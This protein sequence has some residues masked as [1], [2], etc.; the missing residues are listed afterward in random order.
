MR[1]LAIKFSFVILFS[2]I[3][4]DYA[5]CQKME[6]LSDLKITD[7]VY[8]I[9]D[10]EAEFPGGNVY[11]LKFIQE[12]L[13]Y[14]EGYGD[15]DVVGKIYVK[16]VVSKTGICRDFQILR[17]MQDSK[18]ERSTIEMLKKMPVWKPAKMNGKEVDSYYILP[19]YIE[20]N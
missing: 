2:A 3:S 12:N 7:S 1:N 11:L 19:V 16:F 14:P 20:P 4:V 15:I 9:V 5:F 13:V 8:N 6:E 10:E 18:L 17:G